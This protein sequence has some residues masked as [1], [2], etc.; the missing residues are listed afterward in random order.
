MKMHFDRIKYRYF[1]EIF[2]EIAFL[3]SQKDKVLLYRMRKF[4]IK[5]DLM[6]S[7]EWIDYNMSGDIVSIRTNEDFD[8][9]IKLENNIYIKI[10][11]SGSNYT[12]E[13]IIESFHIVDEHSE[14]FKVME[15]DFQN[16]EEEDIPYE[17]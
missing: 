11:F 12:Q 15:D 3:L 7:K 5:E 6:F 17:F 9:I 16:S 2:I 14:N 4:E 8:Q 10:C 1:S 13:G